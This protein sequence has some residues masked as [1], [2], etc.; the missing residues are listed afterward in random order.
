[1]TSHL[2]IAQVASVL[3]WYPLNSLGASR[4]GFYI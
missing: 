2:S 3:Y 4:L 1:M